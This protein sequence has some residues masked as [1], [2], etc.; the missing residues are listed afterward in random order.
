MVKQ[1]FALLPNPQM[2]HH[3]LAPTKALLQSGSKL[4]LPYSS[5]SSSSP[6]LH[7]SSLEKVGSMPVEI[8]TTSRHRSCMFAPA[9]RPSR[10]LYTLDCSASLGSAGASVDVRPV[11]LCDDVLEA[12]AAGDHGQHVLNV[13]HL[14]DVEMGASSG[15]RHVCCEAVPVLVLLPLLCSHKQRESGLKRTVCTMTSSRKGPGVSSISRMAARSSLGWRT[16]F[17]GTPKPRA[18]VTKSG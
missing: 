1:Q 6:Q 5:K 15:T 11:T 13:R 8:Y 7:D 18:I 3:A 9:N 16:R 10:P 2:K 12:A 17:E 4:L 14:H